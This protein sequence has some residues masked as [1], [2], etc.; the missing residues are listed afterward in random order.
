MW[1]P[2]HNWPK[3]C[4]PCLHA[5]RTLKNSLCL[6]CIPH[7]QS[8]CHFSLLTASLKRPTATMSST[9]VE[10]TK[11]YD[12]DIQQLKEKD[13]LHSEILVNKDLMTDAFQ[14]EDS[15]HN[16]TVWQA[17]VSH[18]MACFW[19]FVMCFT[20]SVIL[21]LPNLVLRCLNR[22]ILS[23]WRTPTDTLTA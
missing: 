14:G 5:R 9:G 18:K 13:T 17:V 1:V 12:V 23:R 15:E 4:S 16:Q 11:H 3:S 6:S 8:D 2:L 10:P 20:M 21:L 22:S 7:L 19:A